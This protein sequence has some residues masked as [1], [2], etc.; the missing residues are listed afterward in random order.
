MGSTHTKDFL[1]LLFIFYKVFVLK[2]ASS[3]AFQIQMT[4]F[5]SGPVDAVIRILG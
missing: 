1:L 3:P 2:E 5:C 4:P